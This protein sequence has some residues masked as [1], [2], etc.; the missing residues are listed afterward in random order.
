M[1]FGEPSLCWSERPKDLS[2]RPLSHRTSDM[3]KTGSTVGFSLV[4]G[5][6]AEFKIRGAMYFKWCMVCY[7]TCDLRMLPERETESKLSLSSIAVS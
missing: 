1:V 7:D 4:G 6:Y 3:G 2:N 5:D